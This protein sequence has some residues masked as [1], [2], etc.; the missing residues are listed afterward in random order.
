MIVKRS[1]LHLLQFWQ[2][3]LVIITDTDRHILSAFGIITHYKQFYYRLAIGVV[4]GNI[5]VTKSIMLGSIFRE[6]RDLLPV[7]KMRW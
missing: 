7:R 6:R 5:R 4:A 1:Q 3:Q 2:V